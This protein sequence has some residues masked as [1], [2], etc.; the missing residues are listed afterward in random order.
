MHIVRSQQYT[1]NTV[2][3]SVKTKSKTASKLPSASNECVSRCCSKFMRKLHEVPRVDYV[4]LC[5]VMENVKCRMISTRVG[6]LEI[7]SH[8]QI[9]LN[10]ILRCKF[11]NVFSIIES[12]SMLLVCRRVSLICFSFTFNTQTVL[13]KTNVAGRQLG[14]TK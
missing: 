9:Y 4:I 11:L 6:K 1:T 8:N 13:N 14:V 12:F 7:L 10:S 3:C 5:Y 2:I